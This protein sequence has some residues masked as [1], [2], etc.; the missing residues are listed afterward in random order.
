MSI[1]ARHSAGTTLLR[2]PHHSGA[3]GD[4]AVELRE[5]GDAFELAAHFYNRVGAVGEI[6]AGV[7]RF[8]ANC[9]C[10]IADPF[11]SCFEFSF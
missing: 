7:G 8:S 3:D 9:Q 6:D 4:A 2:V 10:V 5:G 1:S 11:S